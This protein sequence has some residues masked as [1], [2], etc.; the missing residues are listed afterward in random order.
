MSQSANPAPVLLVNQMRAIDNRFG[1]ICYRPIDSMTSYERAL[2]KHPER[3]LAKLAASITE[4]GF[5]IPVLIEEAG[6]IIAGEARVLAARRLGMSEVPVIVAEQWS[7]AQVR[8]YRLADNRLA[9]LASWDEEALAIELA[10]IIELDEVEIELLGWD[11]GEID[12]ILEGVASADSAPDPADEQLEPPVVPVSQAGNLW[13][14]GK[15]RLLCDS[16]LDP[17]SWSILMDGEVAAMCFADAPY[18]VPVTGHVCGLGKVKHAEFAM[19][20]GEMSRSQFTQFLSEF[21]GAMLPHLKDGAVL[22]LCMDWRHLGELTAAT[23]ANS[24]SQ[25]NLCVWNKTNGGM[26]SLYR[27]KHELVV[28]AKKGK[29]PH[30]NNVELGRHGRYRTNVWDYAGVNTFSKSRMTDLSDH[31]TVK[32]IA[33]VADAIRDVSHPGEIVLDGFMG[34]GTTILAAER[35]MRRGYGI[36][37]DPAYVDVAIRRWQQMAGEEAVLASTGQTF[38]EVMD[39]RNESLPEGP[40]ELAGDPQVTDSV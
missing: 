29:A 38:A 12:L 40:A 36:E 9:E 34:S 28:I 8:A 26:G 1:P 33:L 18:N 11:T 35:T 4:F 10:A 25:L 21:L 22:D 39:E 14:L 17:A 13:L 27:S 19:A 16:S 2:R 6:V 31:P 15:H 32:P 23:D 20:S 5:V 7:K 3:Q 30:T 37:I 24:L